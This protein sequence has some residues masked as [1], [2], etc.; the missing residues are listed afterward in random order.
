MGRKDVEHQWIWERCEEFDTDP[1]GYL[2][3]WG[4]GH[5]K[6]TII[7]IAGTIREILASHGD[8]PLT[9]TE[10]AVG[11]FSHT[12]PSAK[13]FLSTI[14]QEFER[15]EMLRSLFPDVIWEKPDSEAPKWGEDAGLILKRKRV[16]KEA[17]VEAW[18]LVDGQPTGSHF[19]HLIYDDVVTIGS[20]SSADMIRKTNEA[21]ELSFNLGSGEHTIR[22]MIGTRYRGDDTYHMVITRGIAKVR[23]HPTCEGGVP[24]G[25][26]V[27]VSR[28]QVANLRRDLGPYTFAAQHLQNPMADSAQGF[29]REWVRRF[30][31]DDG[32]NTGAGMNLYMLV[33][34]ANSKRK[35]SDWTVIAVVALAADHNY[36][37]LDV[38][39]DRLGLR[40]R[41]DAVIEMHQ[42]WSSSSGRQL[43]GVGYE[44]YGLQSD[45]EYL[46]ERMARENYRF[47]ITSVGGQ[48]AKE[49]RIRRLV[50]LFA[51]GRFYLPPSRFYTN[52][53]RRNSDLINDLLEQELLVWPV[54]TQHDDML[55]ALSRIH[56]LP[57]AFPRLEPREDRYT[58]TQR[59]SLLTR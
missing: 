17:T 24:E 19:T 44:Q 42:R 57:T 13:K 18:G 31:E 51:D 38:I 49:D 43:L 56:D 27:L 10:C 35:K 30:R 1:N 15:N 48:M 59:R 58:K 36:Y 23:L 22:R 47:S 54:G 50:P 20:V 34:P 8:D 28:E 4:R 12:R 21:F 52:Y 5:F 55:D 16:R 53:E 46:D 25:R 9:D 7:T 14:K 29:K 45:I 3:L 26:P 11:I 32:T 33:D 2:D 40:E 41:G 37:L 39:R 6:S